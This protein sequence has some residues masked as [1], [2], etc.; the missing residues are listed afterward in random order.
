[1]SHKL[2]LVPSKRHVILHS[3]GEHVVSPRADLDVRQTRRVDSI[4]QSLRTLQYAVP[5]DSSD[6]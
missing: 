2:F 6:L 4:E 3:C 1:M 5:D